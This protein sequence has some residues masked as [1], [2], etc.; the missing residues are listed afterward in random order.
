[1]QVDDVE[2]K[3]KFDKWLKQQEKPKSETMIES[4]SWLARKKAE[5]IKLLMEKGEL[6]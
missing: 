2:F 5:F 3:E 1:M 6:K 4:L